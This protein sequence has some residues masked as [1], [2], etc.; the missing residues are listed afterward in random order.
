MI[1]DQAVWTD[2]I[3]EV[4]RIE[5]PGRQVYEF[6]VMRCGYHDMRLRNAPGGSKELVEHCSPCGDAL[7]RVGSAKQLVEQNSAAWSHRSR[8]RVQVIRLQRCS[9]L[10]AG[11]RPLSRYS[12]ARE[13][14]VH[15]I[16]R[17]AGGDRL[18]KNRIDSDSSQNVDT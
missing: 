14:L 1:E 2:R 10:P 18:G 8:E 13:I 5:R 17:Q 7:D 16:A 3:A 9:I 4:I 6:P 11:D 12:C 15:D